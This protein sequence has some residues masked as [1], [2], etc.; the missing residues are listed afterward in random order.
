MNCPTEAATSAAAKGGGG[1]GGGQATATPRSGQLPGGKM[2]ARVQSWEA[3]CG[4]VLGIPLLGR[5]G[6]F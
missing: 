1:S 6:K 2:G 3:V 4:G 5:L